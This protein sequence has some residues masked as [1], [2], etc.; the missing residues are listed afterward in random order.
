MFLVTFKRMFH[1]FLLQFLAAVEE[2][3]REEFFILKNRIVINVFISGELEDFSLVLFLS[4]PLSLWQHLQ[5]VR[6]N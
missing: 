5:G 2:V 4:M 6:T 1:L 3:E